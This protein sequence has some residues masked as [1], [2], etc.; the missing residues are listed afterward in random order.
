LFSH[1]PTDPTLLAFAREY[2]CYPLAVPFCVLFAKMMRARYGASFW[3]NAV[4]SM[5]T[6]PIVLYTSTYANEHVE[7]AQARASLRKTGHHRTSSW[8]S[9]RG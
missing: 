2:F 7:S 1:A 9:S 4:A 3:L 8:R 6:Y 5:L